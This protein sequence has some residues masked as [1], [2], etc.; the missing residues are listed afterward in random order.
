ML[1]FCVF[2][3]RQPHL[4][5]I[6][7]FYFSCAFCNHNTATRRGKNT[8]VNLDR[9]GLEKGMPHV[10]KQDVERKTDAQEGH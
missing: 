5:N 8:V 6:A 2:M 10:H 9:C 1:S 3:G 7:T 4:P